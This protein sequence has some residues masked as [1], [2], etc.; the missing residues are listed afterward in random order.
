[1][2]GTI[3]VEAMVN[4]TKWGLSARWDKLTNKNS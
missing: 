1:M 3:V 2:S 4:V